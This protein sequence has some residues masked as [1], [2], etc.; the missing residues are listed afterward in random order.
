[1]TTAVYFGLPS[2]GSFVIAQS[3]SYV[4]LSWL[5]AAMILV[6]VVMHRPAARAP[7]LL[8]AAGQ[9]SEAVAN[10]LYHINTNVLHIDPFPSSAD[11]FFQLRYPLVAL[12]LA[13]FVRRRT[14]GWHSPT[15][16]DAAVVGTAAAL[17]LWVYVIGPIALAPGEPLFPKL[18][19]IGMPVGDLLV[20]ALCL[21]LGLGAGARSTAFLLLLGSL[22]AMLLGDVVYGYQTAADTYVQ[23]TALDATWLAT[24]TLLGAAVLHP[25]MRHMDE[26]C[27]VAAPDATRGRLAVLAVASLLAPA[28]LVVEQYRDR[29]GSDLVIAG[30]CAVLFVLV[31]ARMH[32]LVS[33]QR[34]VAITDGLTGLY[35][36]GF[37]E[38]NLRVE[39]G[40]IERGGHVGVLIVDADHFKDVND[41]YGHPVG[42]HVLVELARR[43]RTVCRPGDVVARYGGEEF[44]LLM[45]SAGPADVAGLAE[46]VRHVVGAQPFQIN[47]DLALQVTVSVGAASIPADASDADGVVVVADRALYAAKR[48]GRNRVVTAAEIPAATALQTPSRI[49]G[50]PHASDPTPATS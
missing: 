38:E 42:D 32:G 8:L 3:L 39:V 44:A 22:G 9:F 50:Q 49:L 19:S 6:G 15:M 36:R 7:W 45:P 23:Y 41:T 48:S 27:T 37:L 47:R 14:P 43:M 46:R 10:T 34:Q 1:M 30:G 17:V 25:S 2:L 35:T 26:R 28:V 12:A 20:L 13:G 29:S 21:R 33:A 11:A 5:S 18:V 24:Y 4:T 40:R 31:L 16:I